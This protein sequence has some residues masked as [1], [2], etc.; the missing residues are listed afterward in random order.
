MAQLISLQDAAKRLNVPAHSLRRA[1]DR[2]GMLIK[3]GGLVRVEADRL[4][5]LIDQ[6]RQPA[7]QG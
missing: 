5:A 6:C 2:H 4:P 1:A 7:G 3:I